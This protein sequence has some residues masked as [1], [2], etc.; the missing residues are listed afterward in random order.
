MLIVAERSPFA[1]GSNLTTKVDEPPGSIVGEGAELTVK[2]AAFVPENRI[3]AIL[4]VSFP[5]LE[6]RNVRVIEPVQTKTD[7]KLVKSVVE[8]ERSPSTIVTE[9]PVTFTSG[10]STVP[11]QETPFTTPPGETKFEVEPVKTKPWRVPLLPVPLASVRVVIAV[12]LPA[13]AP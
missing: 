8:G 2:S 10:S 6:I 13:G 1:E 4:S 9:F 7:P 11:E 3:L 12:L 5:E